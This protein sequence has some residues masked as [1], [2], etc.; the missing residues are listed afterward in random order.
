MESK[1]DKFKRLA[2][3]RTNDILE[4]I[5]ILGNLS[6]RG[7]YEYSDVEV[8][9]VFFAIEEALKKT[10][11][12]FQAKVETKK[13]ELKKSGL[14][15]QNTDK[16][17]EAEKKQENSI[18][19]MNSNS[20][21]VPPMTENGNA[22]LDLS[23]NPA[24]V[25][26]VRVIKAI[27]SNRLQNIHIDAICEFGQR[28]KNVFK[29]NGADRILDAAKFLLATNIQTIKNVGKMVTD[30]I[31][32]GLTKFLSG[33][34]S[35]DSALESLLTSTMAT[36]EYDI[37]LRHAK[38]DTLEEIGNDPKWTPT[39]SRQRVDQ[40]EEKYTSNLIMPL[41]DVVHYHWGNKT[42]F[43]AQELREL[44]KN[45][46]FGTLLVSILSKDKRLTEYAYL[47]FAD[48][49]VK[50]DIF[51]DAEERI[52]SLVTDFIGDGLDLFENMENLDELFLSNGYDFMDLDSAIN[53]LNEHGFRFY[54][55]YVIK[56]EKGKG[57]YGALCAN[58]IKTHFPNGIKI[59]QEETSS[60]PD[61]IELRRLAKEA[62]GNIGLPDSDRALSATLQR[63]LVMCDSGKL[64]SEEYVQIDL[65]VLED[66]KKCI[67]SYDTEKVYYSE[68][69]AKYAGSLQ[70]TSNVNNHHFLHGV[71][72]LY[73]PNDYNYTAKDYLTRIDG[74]GASGNAGD[75]IY[76]FIC[77]KNRPVSRKEMYLKFP[78]FTK[79]MFDMQFDNDPRLLQWGYDSYS[80]VDLVSFDEKELSTLREIVKASVTANN[81]FS[82]DA[83]VFDAASAVLG[84]FIKKNEM[85]QSGLFYFCSKKFNDEFDFRNPNIGR[86]GILDVLSMKNIALTLLNHPTI[87]SLPEYMDVAKRMKWSAGS[88]SSAFYKM[89]N[90]Y[91][92]ISRDEYHLDQLISID[93]NVIDYVET[94]LNSELLNKTY[95]SLL[96]MDDFSGFPKMEFEWNVFIFE[97]IVKKYLPQFKVIVPDSKDRRV[98]RSLIIRANQGINT[99]SELI[100]QVFE[101]S[102]HKELSEGAFLSFLVSNGL[103]YKVIP[104]ELCGSGVFRIHKDLYS[105]AE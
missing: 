45:E 37:S 17:D 85:T 94:Y 32:S 35:F 55:D 83:L 104:K 8:E 15:E 67:D 23:D 58:L 50:T 48:V 22:P 40:K 95:V 13:F 78:G 49:F 62:Y 103:T 11:E 27:L 6:N 84:D 69:F 102:K 3:K 54:R 20:A 44:Y 99:Y 56:T 92:R 21:P 59:S 88:I 26:E 71:L 51:P 46:D 25:L 52:C 75:R 31:S 16:K 81:G 66:I 33:V 61:L 65:N 96:T 5:R 36:R 47:D 19:N 39:L 101:E 29:D 28:T 91:F 10:K 105:L 38:G 41:M 30:E 1:N 80:V 43:S 2:E 24:D 42:W 9:Q 89:E 93:Q 12:L 73:Y 79:I 60:C 76:K 97:S 86:K 63:Y 70:R 98:P 87:L 57:G 4:S 68:L 77:E 72:K 74:I 100:A 18:P 7:N 14:P 82:S 90:N 34:Y 53:F 64:I